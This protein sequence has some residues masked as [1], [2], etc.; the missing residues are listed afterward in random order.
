MPKYKLSSRV[1]VSAQTTVEADS[2]ADAIAEAKGREV[3]IG[4][5]HSGTD[6]AESWVIDDAD[7]EATDI[8]VES[9][10]A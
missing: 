9:E 5:L 6:D 7:G 8:R 3:V 10:D 2:E 1:T 4:G